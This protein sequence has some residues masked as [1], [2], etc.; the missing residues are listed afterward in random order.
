MLKIICAIFLVLN[1]VALLSFV[2][3]LGPETP[4]L[5]VI[6]FCVGMLFSLIGLV[7]SIELEERRE[8]GTDDRE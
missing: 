8:K 4:M 2:M 3:I 1:Y 5:S 7:C 6:C